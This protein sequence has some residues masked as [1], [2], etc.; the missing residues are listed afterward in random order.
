MEKSNL[1]KLF[2]SYAIEGGVALG[3]LQLILTILFFGSDSYAGTLIALVLFVG[4]FYYY[5]RRYRNK[6]LPSDT[7][8]YGKAF[9]FFMAIALCAGVVSSVGSGFYYAYLGDAEITRIMLEKIQQQAMSSGRAMSQ[10]EIDMGLKIV[11]SPYYL[12]GVG[13]MSFLCSGAVIGAILAAFVRK[14]DSDVIPEIEEE[15]E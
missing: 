14:K 1:K 3:L 13:M 10:A 5:G 12:F 9:S 11:T 4:A 7:F 8:P 15:N 2:W 6:L